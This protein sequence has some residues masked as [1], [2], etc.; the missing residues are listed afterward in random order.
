MTSAGRGSTG[1][2][3]A[4]GIEFVKGHGTQNDFLVVFDPDRTHDVDT[5]L[6][7]RMCDRRAGIGADG[8]LRVMRE[9]S[10]S[11]FMDY[12][13]ADGSV[14]EMCGNGVRVFARYLAAHQLVDPSRPL[15]VA[16]RGGPKAVTFEDDGDISVDMGCGSRGRTVEIRAGDQLL[17]A[18][19]VDMGNPHAVVLVDDGTDRGHGRNGGPADRRGEI[20][21]QGAGAGDRRDAA[22]GARLAALDLSRPPE[23]DRD[24]FPRGVNVEFVAWLGPRH[25]AMRVYERGVGETRSCGTGA[26][27][28]HLALVA[29]EP[30]PESDASPT[31]IDVAGGRLAVRTDAAGHVHLRGPAVL[32]AAGTYFG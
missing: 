2:H 7:R 13:N 29:D 9:P 15:V 11:W 32:T 5:G 25:L 14:A 4:G 12:R 26:C 17:S 1:P 16:T 22:T 18:T 20:E 10:G 8:I 3:R 6:V 19:S 28:A 31:V 21:D 30:G 23:Y 24:E 27:A